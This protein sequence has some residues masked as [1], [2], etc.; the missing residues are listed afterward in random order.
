M[1]W[2]YFM[3]TLRTNRCYF[4]YCTLQL[5][6]AFGILAYIMTDP[7]RNIKQFGV[8]VVEGLLTMILFG[9]IFLKLIALKQDYFKS[10]WNMADL[11]TMVAMLLILVIFI[12]IDPLISDNAAKDGDIFELIVISIRYFIQ[13]ARIC[14]I[15]KTAANAHQVT[16]LVHEDIR[17]DVDVSKKATIIDDSHPTTIELSTKIQIRQ[18]VLCRSSI[19]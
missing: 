16:T 5:L 13:L 7:K 6:A 2:E 4:Y 19:E 12:C 11:V 15:I 8:L 1:N 9:D 3:R 14:F 17:F 18:Q 10:K